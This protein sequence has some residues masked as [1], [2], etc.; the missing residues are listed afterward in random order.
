MRFSACRAEREFVQPRF[1]DEC[2]TRPRSSSAEKSPLIVD[3]GQSQV[4][5]ESTVLDLT[6]T[7]PKV[8]RPG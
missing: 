7:P 3:G 6:V 5:I 2:G 8:L 1:T 4:G